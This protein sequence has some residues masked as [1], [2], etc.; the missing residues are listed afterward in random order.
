MLSITHGVSEVQ[1]ILSIIHVGYTNFFISDNKI[2]VEGTPVVNLL[3][4]KFWLGFVRKISIR[5]RIQATCIN[6]IPHIES[7]GDINQT[8]KRY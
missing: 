8:S 4:S 6:Q 1:S 5:G 3:Q 7:L 2:T